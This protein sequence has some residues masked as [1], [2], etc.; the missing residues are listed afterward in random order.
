[1]HIRGNFTI[2]QTDYGITPY[3]K[4]FGAIGVANPL[5]IYGDLY[6]APTSQVDM[7]VIPAGD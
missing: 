5:R 6:V 3:S 7:K 1:L 4:A 2:L